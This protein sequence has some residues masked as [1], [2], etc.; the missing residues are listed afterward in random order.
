MSIS[1]RDQSLLLV[2]LG[3]VVVLLA[4]FFVYNNFKGKADAAQAENASLQPRLEELQSYYSNLPVY[5]DGIEEISDKVEKELN[6]FPGDVRSEDMIVYG[7]ELETKLGL[8]VSNMSF[9]EPQ[10]VSQFSVPKQD[11]ND[12]TVL[13]PYAALS[14]EMNISAQMSYKQMLDFITYIYDKSVHTTLENIS[15]SYD[16]ETGNLTGS[17][18]M[19]K[20]FMSDSEYVYEETKV[21]EYTSGVTN[22]FGTTT[23]GAGSN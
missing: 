12:E 21:G 11:E 20:Y 18:T 22:P 5:Q 2:L 15:V 10:L 3:L 19:T 7:N 6:S 23:G 13:V 1:K 8:T 17:A 16:S 14:A 9:S 4:Y